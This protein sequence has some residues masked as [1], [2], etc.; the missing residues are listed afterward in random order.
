AA[1]R[2]AN[3][4]AEARES[5]R[6]GMELAGRCGADAL[7]QRAHEEL[8]VAGARP[9]RL[10]F[11]GPEAL[12]PSERRVA[13]LAAEGQSNREIAQALFVTTKT[14]EVHLTSAYRKLDIGSR[15]QLAGALAPA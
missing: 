11:S 9:R 4:R 1:L 7:S 13:E 10:M 12:T 5:L 2:R 8:L 15:V 14:V 6:A 3:R